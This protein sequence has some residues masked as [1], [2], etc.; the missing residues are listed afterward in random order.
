MSKKGIVSIVVFAM[1]VVVVLKVFLLKSANKEIKMIKT[2]TNIYAVSSQSDVV[3]TQGLDIPTDL[4]GLKNKIYE[5]SLNQ[6]DRAG[7]LENLA[8]ISTEISLKIIA[9]FI[10]TPPEVLT[11]AETALRVQAI[12]AIMIYPDKDEAIIMLEKLEENHRTG[13]LGDRMRRAVVT[14]RFQKTKTQ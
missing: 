12:D 2:E 8:K 13:V 3:T 4:L 14:L 5:T 9:E 6:K 11:P 7:A 1:V 10:V